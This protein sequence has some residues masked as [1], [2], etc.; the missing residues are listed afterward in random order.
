LEDLRNYLG[1]YGINVPSGLIQRIFIVNPLEYE[2]ERNKLYTLTKTK[3][4]ED[5]DGFTDPFNKIS[6]IRSNLTDAYTQQ[7]AVHEASH[8]ME[9]TEFWYKKGDFF[10]RRNG[11]GTARPETDGTTR[12][13]RIPGAYAFQEG[14][15]DYVADQITA[16]EFSYEAE[17]IGYLAGIMGIGPILKASYTKEGFRELHK[18]MEEMFGGKTLE[19]VLKQMGRELKLEGE[20]EEARKQKD[21]TLLDLLSLQLEFRGIENAED[22]RPYQATL[23]YMKK[24]REK[25]LA[26]KR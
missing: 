4:E 5:E 2:T 16:T 13:Y 25:V 18:K 8:L 22:Y 9:H 12:E 7:V 14:V 6:F 10:T 24:R 11:A 20:I 21:F 17:V 3:I 26:Q 19:G 1:S 23:L 15:A